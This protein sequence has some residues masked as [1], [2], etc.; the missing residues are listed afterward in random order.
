MG[1]PLYDVAT[2]LNNVPDDGRSDSEIVAILDR[3][4]QQLS[5]ILGFDRQLILGWGQAQC[6][7]SGYWTFEDHG[8]GW[9]GTFA[10]AELYERLLK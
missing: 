8:E 10:F 7:L 2:F 3:R 1:N 5:E 6:V 9:E 4:A